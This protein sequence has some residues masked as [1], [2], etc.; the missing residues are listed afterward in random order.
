MQL[1]LKVVLVSVVFI[2]VLGCDTLEELT[3]PQERVGKR[4]ASGESGGSKDHE[5]TEIDGK[6]GTTSTQPSG[7]N[8]PA[9]G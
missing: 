7:T 6:T 2:V 3:V 9:T 1:F 8:N 4:P 5:T